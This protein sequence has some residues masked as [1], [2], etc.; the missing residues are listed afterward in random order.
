MTFWMAFSLCS[1][2]FGIFFNKSSNT[3]FTGKVDGY[4]LKG[5]LLEG[6]KEGEWFS[7]FGNRILKSKGLLALE[8]GNDQYLKVSQILKS[9]FFRTKYLIKDFKNNIRCILSELNF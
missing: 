1:L 6:K 4:L 3:P 9:N 5:S 2:W 7:Y 8:I